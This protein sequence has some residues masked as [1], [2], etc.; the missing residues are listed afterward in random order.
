MGAS[1]VTTFDSLLDS[2]R[3]LADSER[4]KGSYFEQLIEQYLEHDGVQAP[5]Y[6]NVWLWRD[7][8]GR[9]GKPDT[10]IDLV[11]ERADGGIT[12]I[13]C[14][15]YAETH[16]MQKQDIDSFIS[17]SGKEP[18]THRLIVSTTS[19]WTQNAEEMLDSQHIPVQRIGLSDFRHSNID[20]STYEL[21]DPSTAPKL[22][23][24]K[25][26]RPHQHEA[27]TATMKGFI[28]NNRG[29]LIMACGTGKTFTALKVAER[30]AE[31]EGHARI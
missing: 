22:H 19:K 21:T 8:P 7:W 24:K 11:A 3:A 18:F 26:L 2:Y 12:A 5:Q 9:N 28:D 10:G 29:K 17:A 4:M 16:T 14:K 13:Q 15:F 31:M 20:W 25:Q 1:L 6:T 27:V 23:E 30:F